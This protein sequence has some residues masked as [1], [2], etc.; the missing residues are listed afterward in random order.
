[1]KKQSQTD[2]RT[3]TLEEFCDFVDAEPMLPSSTLDVRIMD[4]VQHDLQ[5]SVVWLYSKFFFI[6]SGAGV[7]TLFFCPQFGLSIGQQNDFFHVLH[8]QTGF[9]AFYLICGL[10]FVIFGA[11]MSA[12]LLSYNELQS[13]K[14]S[15]YLYYLVFGVTAFLAFF[16]AGGVVLWLSAVPWI[17]GAYLGN[18]TGFG[19]VSRL[20]LTRRW[21]Q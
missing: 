12:L 16:I 10:L 11:A 6:E 21:V 4:R 17:V 1:M 2:A 14:K 7:A 13:I 8:E 9:F 5:P 3:P 20:R 15:K 18:F 19:V